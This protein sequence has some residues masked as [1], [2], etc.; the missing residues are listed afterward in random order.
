MIAVLTVVMVPIGAPA[1]IAQPVTVDTYWVDDTVGV[2]APGRG[3]EAE[4][5]ETITYAAAVADALDTIVV[6][7]GA[8]SSP[9]DETLPLP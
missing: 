1:G 3:S 5:F 7:P 8:Y 9:K 6:R 4:P 2:N